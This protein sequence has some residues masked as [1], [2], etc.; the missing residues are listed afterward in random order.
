MTKS[1]NKDEILASSSGLIASVLN[2]FPG[3][4]TGYIYQRRWLPYFLTGGAITIWIGL[5][6]LL[7]GDNEPTRKEQ[8]IGLSGLLFISVVTAIE[9]YLAFNR[10]SKIVEENTL[11]KQITPTKKGW[12]RN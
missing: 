8:L 12:F 9:S 11:Q 1:L 3:L 5:G 6:I 4:G 2:L 7:Q 10:A